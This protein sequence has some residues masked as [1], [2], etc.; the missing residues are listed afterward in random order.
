VFG[1]VLTSLKFF[2][3]AVS[4]P[5]WVALAG[6]LIFSMGAGPLNPI[7]GAVKYERVPRDMRGRVF[8]AVG[9][10]AW[11]AMPLGMLAGGVLTEQF[12]AHAM[13]LGLGAI[14]FLTTLSMAFIPAMKEMNRKEPMNP[15]QAEA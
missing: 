12:G 15:V 6:V 3:Y 2:L 1:F 11:S 14:Y 13:L 9:A 5:L 8:G 10:G 7:I 4:P